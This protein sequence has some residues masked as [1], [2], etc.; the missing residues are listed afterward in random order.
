MSLCFTLAAL[1][2]AASAAHQPSLAGG[3][4]ISFASDV[5]A[6]AKPN[7][8]PETPD[9]FLQRQMQRRHI[10][11][12]QVVIARHGQIILSRSFGVANLQD[13]TPVTKDTVFAIYSIT[14]AFTGV[15]ATQ[16]IEQGKLD[17]TA[18]VSRYLD[19]LP[20]AW[21]PITIRQLLTHTSGLPNIVDNDTGGIIAPTEQ[22]AWAKVLAMPLAFAPGE[23]FSYCQ[24]N[25][26]LIGRI[27]DK[28]SNQP[29]TQFITEQQLNKLGMPLTTYGDFH[30]VIPHGVR[31]YSL[32]RGVPDS[33]PI[34]KRYVNEFA[35]FSPGVLTAAGLNT[36]AE[37][38]VRWALAVQQGRFFRDKASLDLLWTPGSLNNG[39]TQGFSQL[40]NGYA[41]GWPVLVRPEHRALAPIGGGRAALFVYPDDDLIIVILTNL[42]RANPEDFVDKLASLYIPSMK[43]DTGFGFPA[44]SKALHAAVM[45]SGG[46]Q[47]LNAA[48]D[49]AAAQGH[50]YK[51]SEQDWEDLGGHLFQIDQ[52]E[53]A[54]IVL[55]KNVALHPD[56]A[57]A[58]DILAVIYH[59]LGNEPLHDKNH[60]RFVELK[61]KE[62][63]P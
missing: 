48:L 26:L 51:L 61:A 28:L 20:S 15:A 27:I 10:P 12:M 36:N 19:G 55:N 58:Y 35:E 9:A 60:Q 1:I 17:L 37:E 16:L 41:L 4:M 42:K 7:S 23:R 30:T 29:F 6:Q 59:Q 43:A 63:K 54:L 39:S 50:P 18:P 13:H 46:Y 33:A 47:Q 57:D 40:F 5:Q 45:S 25:Y 14:K 38:L 53:D 8:Q 3:S 34:S 62:P 44:A 22:S 49:H 52:P 21:Q 56:V 2:L 31:D 24:T 11:G 32:V